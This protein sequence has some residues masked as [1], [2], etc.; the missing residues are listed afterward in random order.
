MLLLRTSLV[1][2]SN[3]VEVQQTVSCSL[4]TWC[5]T[6]TV[7]I[8]SIRSIYLSYGYILQSDL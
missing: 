7:K 2:G 8:R 4:T 6:E 1:V 3:T 5:T